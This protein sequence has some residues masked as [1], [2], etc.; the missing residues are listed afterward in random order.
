M[1]PPQALNTESRLRQ[2]ESSMRTFEP[3]PHRLG[4]LQNVVSR[5]EAQQ[6]Q[7]MVNVATLNASLA[8]SAALISPTGASAPAPPAAST[9]RPTVQLSDQTWDIYRSYI[10]PLTPW[11]PMLSTEV[12]LAGE[13]VACL[14]ARVDPNVKDADS[15]SGRRVRAEIGRLYALGTRFSESDLSALGVFA[16]V[17]CS[18][19]LPTVRASC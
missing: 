18:L 1:T 12:G 9:A 4:T 7:L 10:C 19:R 15:A 6:D 2:L 11:L 8:G 3:L 5:L 13:V 16:C 17:S 14:T